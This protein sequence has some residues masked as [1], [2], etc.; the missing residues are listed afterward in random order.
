MISKKILASDVKKDDEP[1]VV[2]SNVVFLCHFEQSPPINVATNGTGTVVNA[3]YYRTQVITN[4][5]TTAKFGQGYLLHG[6]SVGGGASEYVT[7]PKGFSFGT[8]NFTIESWHIWNAYSSANGATQYGWEL[9]LDTSN[10]YCGLNLSGSRYNG[11]MQL[12]VNRGFNST[13]AFTVNIPGLPSLLP[14]TAYFHVAV[15]R[16][17]SVIRVYTNGILRNSQNIGSLPITEGSL[18]RFGISNNAYQPYCATDE[19]RIVMDQ[20]LYTDDFT[21]PT[22]AFPNPVIE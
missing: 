13:P 16:D 10:N 19:V 2:D 12:T 15:V 22:A 14:T 8:R 5:P 17:G 9:G 20:A 3:G 18:L 11:G 6:G 7:F 4:D 1:I 21:P